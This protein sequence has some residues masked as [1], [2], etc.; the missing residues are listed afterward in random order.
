M[1][2]EEENA[3]N[4]FEDIISRVEHIRDW[5]DKGVFWDSIDN[6][7]ESAQLGP[8]PELTELEWEELD[9]LYGYLELL[10]CDLEDNEP[11]EGTTAHEV[12][13]ALLQ[14]ID[15]YNEAIGTR[16][17]ELEEGES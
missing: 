3:M 16:L 11:D 6:P 2:N 10:R 9:E 8:L 13:D 14:K 1:L 17:W 15:G 4:N 5:I 7:E 12:Y